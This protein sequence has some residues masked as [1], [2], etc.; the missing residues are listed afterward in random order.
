MCLI[1]ALQSG[2]YNYIYMEYTLSIVKIHLAE[3]LEGVYVYL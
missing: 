3:E 2:Y 1:I